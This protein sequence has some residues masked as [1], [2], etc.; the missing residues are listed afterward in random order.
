M[1]VVD[2]LS[3]MGRSHK[4]KETI[5]DAKANTDHQTLTQIA[6]QLNKL[7]VEHEIR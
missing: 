7:V 5:K 4:S 2:L 1:H 6:L 3:I